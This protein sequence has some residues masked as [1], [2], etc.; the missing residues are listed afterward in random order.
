MGKGAVGGGPGLIEL[1]FETR[2]GCLEYT[3][4]NNGEPT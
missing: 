2:K 4:L 3:G 1:T